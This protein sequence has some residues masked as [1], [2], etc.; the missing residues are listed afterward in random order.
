MD[1]ILDSF[2]LLLCMWLCV[3]RGMWNVIVSGGVGVGVVGV[4]LRF[5]FQ[6]KTC[7]SDL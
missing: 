2:L 5:Y 7:K 4:G 6:H 1:Q 3:C